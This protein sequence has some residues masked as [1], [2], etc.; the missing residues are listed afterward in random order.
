MLAVLKAKNDDMSK[1]DQSKKLKDIL[2]T[3]TKIMELK[4]ERM[5]GMKELE[6]LKSKQKIGIEK[7]KAMAS[8]KKLDMRT[9]VLKVEGFDCQLEDVSTASS[10]YIISFHISWH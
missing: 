4:K 2:T 6:V 9:T 8:K 10:V 5:E 1:D 7:K 3:Q